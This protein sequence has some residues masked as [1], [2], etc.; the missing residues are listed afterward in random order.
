MKIIEQFF[1]MW[2]VVYKVVLTFKAMNEI[3]V[4]DHSNLS[5]T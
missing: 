5:K 2:P 1:F 3:M 4:C